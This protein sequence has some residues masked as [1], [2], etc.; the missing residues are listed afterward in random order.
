MF[1]SPKGLIAADAACQNHPPNVPPFMVPR[2][3][4]LDLG[5]GGYAC[6]ENAVSLPVTILAPWPHSVRLRLADTLSEIIQGTHLECLTILEVSVLFQVFQEGG[7]G[8]IL[9]ST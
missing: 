3:L 9:E 2:G 5:W 6:E 4:S 8:Q 7:K 1:A